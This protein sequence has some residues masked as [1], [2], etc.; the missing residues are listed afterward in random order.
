MGGGVMS[1]PKKKPAKK[2]KVRRESAKASAAANLYN[3]AVEIDLH[4]AHLHAAFQ[5]VVG[6]AVTVPH[7]ACELVEDSIA[8]IQWETASM[9]RAQFGLE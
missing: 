1:A 7:K 2:P 4:L 9:R 8:G 6:A 3:Y 5:H